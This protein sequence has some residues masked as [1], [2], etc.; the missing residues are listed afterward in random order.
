MRNSISSQIPIFPF[1][2]T[3]RQTE[4][5]RDQHEEPRRYHISTNSGCWTYI[6]IS[7]HSVVLLHCSSFISLETR[8]NLPAMARNNKTSKPNRVVEPP[9]MTS[10]N[11]F[12]KGRTLL[13][14]PSSQPTNPTSQPTEQPT[15]QPSRQ[16]TK[17]PSGQPTSQPSCQPSRQPTAQLFRQPSTQPSSQPTVRLTSSKPTRRPR[18]SPSKYSTTTAPTLRGQT[19]QPSNFPSSA[20]SY[21]LNY[22]TQST[23]IT[24]QSSLAKYKATPNSYTYSTFDFKG[25]AVGETCSKWTSFTKNVLQ[26]PFDHIA[27]SKIS[28]DVNIMDFDTNI[29]RNVTAQCSDAKILQS[30][31]SKLQAGVTSA[32]NCESRQWRV[33]HCS[34]RNAL[35]VHCKQSCVPDDLKIRIYVHYVRNPYFS[36]GRLSQL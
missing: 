19:N 18:S 20:P 17:Q 23:F 16:P 8:H 35:C 30:I 13:L 31:V 26:L 34:S 22:Q 32:I 15:G 25:L 6:Y 24:Y 5:F 3:G 14:Q 10:R 36:A 33:F 1:S 2:L 9:L 29:V 27:F 11:L 28:L 12:R 7:S 4:G 21:N